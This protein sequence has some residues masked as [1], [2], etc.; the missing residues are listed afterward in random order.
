M[1]EKDINWCLGFFESQASFTVN[2]GL[3]KTKNNR[4]VV[5]KPYVVIANTDSYQVGFIRQLLNLN[6][7]KASKKKKKKEYHNETFSLNVQN[8]DD[9]DKILEVLSNHKFKSKIKQR[10]LDKFKICYE[11][12]KKIGHIHKKWDVEFEEV[13]LEKLDINKFRSNIDKNRFNEEQWV[14]KIKEHLDGKE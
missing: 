8:F 1:E 14:K 2:I 7:S 13:I 5:F 3:P 10:R 4:Y 12:I 9:I 6:S 11:H